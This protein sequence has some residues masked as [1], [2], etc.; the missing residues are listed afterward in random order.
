MEQT[1]HGISVK[2]RIYSFPMKGESRAE[3]IC[4]SF[5]QYTLVDWAKYNKVLSMRSLQSKEQNVQSAAKM[6]FLITHIPPEGILDDGR[7]SL[8]LLL[9]VY[10]SQPRF[11]VFGHAHSCGNQSK[12]GAFTEFYN[13]SQFN[14]LKNQDG[15]Q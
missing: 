6:D 11:H 2:R 10:R 7:G 14:E 5:R 15:G 12:G 13:V 9:E 3:A 4:R 1:K 8:P